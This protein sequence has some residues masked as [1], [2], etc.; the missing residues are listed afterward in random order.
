MQFNKTILAENIKGGVHSFVNE[1]VG[2][3]IISHRDIPMELQF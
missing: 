2:L 3:K 1:L